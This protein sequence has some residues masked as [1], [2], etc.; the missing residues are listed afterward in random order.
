M[1]FWWKFKKTIEE[2]I[3]Y[4]LYVIYFKVDYWDMST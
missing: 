1:K 2:Q 4:T 3:Y